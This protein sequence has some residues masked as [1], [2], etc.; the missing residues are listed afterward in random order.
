M[1]ETLL[2][3]YRLHPKKSEQSKKLQKPYKIRL[4]K[5]YVKSNVKNFPILSGQELVEK[6]LSLN[7]DVTT[8]KPIIGFSKYFVST[9]GKVYTGLL[10]EIKPFNSNGYYQVKLRDDDNVPQVKGV[11]QLVAMTFLSSY[12][13]G[14][15]VHHVDEKRH[16]NTLSNLQVMSNAEHASLHYD[17]EKLSAICKNR[18]PWNKGKKMTDT[19]RQHCR[20]SALKRKKQ[21]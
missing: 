16:N 2:S 12:R 7:I 9:D 13:N 4:R 18:T 21:K 14:C 1:S 8:I 15:V 10:E 20:E 6:A 11:H 3:K 19:F 5:S 17:T